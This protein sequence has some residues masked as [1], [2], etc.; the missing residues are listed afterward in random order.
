MTTIILTDNDK[1]G[2]HLDATAKASGGGG[3]TQGA[4]RRCRRGQGQAGNGHQVEEEDRR[5][6]LEKL[7]HHCILARSLARHGG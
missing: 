3:R 7:H 6:H 2:D 4:D 1:V 5:R